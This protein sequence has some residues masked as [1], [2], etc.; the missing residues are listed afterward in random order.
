MV[1]EYLI[2]TKAAYTLHT[3]NKKHAFDWIVCRLSPLSL[4]KPLICLSICRVGEPQVYQTCIYA[5]NKG[6]RN[7]KT[8]EGFIGEPTSGIINF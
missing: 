1:F 2:F 7:Q 3:R 4:S 8:S 6:L 5:Q